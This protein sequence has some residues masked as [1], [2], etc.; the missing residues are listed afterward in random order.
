V[1]QQHT[2]QQQQTQHQQMQQH[3]HSEHSSINPLLNT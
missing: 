2:Q 1:Q 3:Y